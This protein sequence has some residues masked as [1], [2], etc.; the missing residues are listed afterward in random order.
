[1]HTLKWK[2]ISQKLLNLI[3]NVI[4]SNWTKQIDKVAVFFTIFC[5]QIMFWIS[6]KIRHSIWFYIW[7]KSFKLNV[8][9]S[10]VLSSVFYQF[11]PFQSYF[12]YFAK[13]TA[14]FQTFFGKY[15]FLN[16]T[17][18]SLKEICG[19]RNNSEQEQIFILTKL[20]HRRT[21]QVQ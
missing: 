8:V 16:S 10:E 2:F 6:V 11:F 20:F 7:I 19:F 13:K 1:M 3:S 4:K 5:S 17:N 21:T 18:F 12:R 9:V 15:N 14:L